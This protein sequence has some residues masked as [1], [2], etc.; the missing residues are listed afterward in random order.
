MRDSGNLFKVGSYDELRNSHRG[1][2]EE[3]LGSGA[4]IRRDEW[5]GSIAIGSRS[6][7]ENVKTLLGLRAKGRCVMEDGGGYQLREEAAP[8]ISLFGA[9]KDDIAHENTYYWDVTS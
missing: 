5:T 4:E 8:Y 9:E 2:I 1:W 6:F 3:Y 7:V